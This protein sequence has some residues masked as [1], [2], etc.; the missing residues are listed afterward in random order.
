MIGKLKLGLT[1]AE[2]NGRASKDHATIWGTR[3]KL[4]GKE[5]ETLFRV[6]EGRAKGQ[7]KPRWSEVKPWLPQ[8]NWNGEV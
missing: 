4:P 3:S 2:R 1:A 7:R 5:Q 6:C 8:V